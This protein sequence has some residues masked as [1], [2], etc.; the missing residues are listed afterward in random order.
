MKI[1]DLSHTITPTMPVYPG[2][3]PPELTL[4]CSLEIEGFRETAIHMYSHT[5]THM[6]SPA[7]LF[8]EGKYL[9]QFAP[10]H[11]Y[12]AA[13]VLDV[14]QFEG[15]I[16]QEYLKQYASMLQ[17]V[18]FLLLHTGWSTFWGRPEYFTDFPVLASSAA[19]WLAGLGLKGVGVDAISVD[20][21]QANTLPVHKELLSQEILL[22]ENL[23]NLKQFIN[24]R[25]TFCCLP[26][27][28][29]KADGAPARAIA[30]L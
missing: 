17:Q 10:E 25:F 9:E 27:K 23:T 19:R 20:S 3:A 26:L 1:V 2:T 11:F 5:G 28:T 6:D 16:P 4:A 21:V 22:I 8:E 14:S 29:I 30:I 7:H 24:K 13:V 18:D 15:E 12:G